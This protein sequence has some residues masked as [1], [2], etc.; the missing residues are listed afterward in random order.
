MFPEFLPGV[1]GRVVFLRCKVELN[2]FFFNKKCW[3][4]CR[5]ALNEYMVIVL[6]PGKVPWGIGWKG[7]FFFVPICRNYLFK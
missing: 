7:L 1:V 4:I 2:F 5:E 3:Y 6:G